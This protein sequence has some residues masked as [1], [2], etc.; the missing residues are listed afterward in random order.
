MGLHGLLTG[1]NFN[2]RSSNNSSVEFAKYTRAPKTSKQTEDK[3]NHNIFCRNLNQ[4]STTCK[5]YEQHKKTS[6]SN[7]TTQ[8]YMTP[9]EQV[10]HSTFTAGKTQPLMT[11]KTRIPSREAFDATSPWA[12]SQDTAVPYTPCRPPT[13]LQD[14]SRRAPL[15]SIIHSSA[16][17]AEETCEGGVDL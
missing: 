11:L 2:T 6:S 14:R 17:L 15:Q 9:N 1:I 5:I 4:A 7:V 8:N 10:S 12:A 3:L 13:R 16:S